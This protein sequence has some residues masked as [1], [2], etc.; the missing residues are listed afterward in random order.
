MKVAMRF[1]GGAKLAKALDTLALK[2]SQNV[3]RAA[4]K[5]GAEPIRATSPS[6]TRR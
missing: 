2:P 4:L 1:E 3:M 5:I 6:V